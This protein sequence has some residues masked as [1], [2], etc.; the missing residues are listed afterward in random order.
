MI[1]ADVGYRKETDSITSL[2]YWQ[3]LSVLEQFFTPEYF[4]SLIYERTTA[5]HGI[6]ASGSTLKGLGN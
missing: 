5:P 4:T 1:Q 3:R 2:S 6:G